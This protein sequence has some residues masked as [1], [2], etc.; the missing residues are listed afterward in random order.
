MNH[1]TASCGH[2]VPAV[3][4][5]GSAARAEC[6]ESACMDCKVYETTFR[7]EC[8]E[9]IETIMR[10]INN[11]LTWHEMTAE[12]RDSLTRSLNALEI[13]RCRLRG[14]HTGSPIMPE[15]L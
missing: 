15:C 12:M 4:A 14:L 7:C 1:V 6:E 2:S 9:S 11:E 8:A 13:A 5:P 3:G 10:K